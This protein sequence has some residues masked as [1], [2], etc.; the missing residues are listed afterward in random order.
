VT[1]LPAGRGPRRDIYLV[2]EPVRSLAFALAAMGGTRMVFASRRDPHVD[3]AVNARAGAIAAA[4]AQVSDL[5]R[6]DVLGVEYWLDLDD[7]TPTPVAHRGRI[8]FDLNLREARASEAL[9]LLAA[10]EPFQASGCSDAEAPI[11]IVL[12]RSEMHDALTAVQVLSRQPLPA[13]DGEPPCSVV[14][15][16]TAR[17]EHAKLVG[18]ITGQATVAG[19]RTEQG[20]VV[21]RVGTKLADATVTSIEP[22]SVV[23]TRAKGRTRTVLLHPAT[24]A[25]VPPPLDPAR[26]RL[27]ATL[28]GPRGA[29]AVVDPGDERAPSII[30]ARGTGEADRIEIVP[31]F[32]TIHQ[33]PKPPIELQLRR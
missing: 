23:V 19:L 9:A 10:A 12:A 27:S 16:T 33:Y 30:R 1:Q 14:E 18:T 2:D 11:S 7:P 5:K 29:S 31:T 4:V 20:F 13:A 8:V 32:A 17:L 6:H 22:V 28:I 3:V 25:D 26:A 24:S 15:P 21:V